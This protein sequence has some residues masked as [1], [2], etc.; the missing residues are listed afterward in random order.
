MVSVDFVTIRS[1]V[2]PPTGSMQGYHWGRHP[3]VGWGRQ[4]RVGW[5]R[6]PRVG[7]R[8]H[9]RVGWRRHPRVRWRRH[10]RVRRWGPHG[11]KTSTGEEASHRRRGR[12]HP[13]QRWGFVVQ[14]GTPPSCHREP[15]RS[16]KLFPS[17]FRDDHPDPGFTTPVRPLTQRCLSLMKP[18]RSRPRSSAAGSFY[19]PLSRFLTPSKESE[20]LKMPPAS[21]VSP[22]DVHMRVLSTSASWHTASTNKLTFHDATTQTSLFVQ[23]WHSNL[24]NFYQTYLV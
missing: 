3:W 6:Q 2:F 13:R 12:R 22:K 9:P 1:L 17:S 20:W 11:N 24:K 18:E 19:S 16:R 7:W 23:H 4:P 10:S 21:R 15:Q 8:R 5:G 14:C